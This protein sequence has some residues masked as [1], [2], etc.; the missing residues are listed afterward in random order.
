MTA[1]ASI[2]VS[3]HPSLLIV[4]SP[5]NASFSFLASIIWVLYEISFPIAFL[6]SL[7][8]TFV[9]IPLAKLENIPIDI[10]FHPLPI[11]MHNANILF[12][13]I[14]FL[15]NNISFLPNHVIFILAYGILYVYFAWYWH[16]K[17]GVYYYFFLDYTRPFAI[18]WYIALLGINYGLF[19]LGEY[20]NA[21]K[22]AHD[23]LIPRLVMP[24]SLFIS[25][26][27]FV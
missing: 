12:M 13:T 14:E 3:F 18:L 19:A 20:C 27:C 4:S 5:D 21:W 16:E 6:V 23:G 10:F 25:F 26:F 17:K 22:F 15:L 8:V 24:L 11:I 2:S 9:L 1:Y 7:V